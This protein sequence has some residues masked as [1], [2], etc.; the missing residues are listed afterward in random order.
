MAVFISHS[1][2]ETFRWAQNYA[3]SLS[4][5]DVVLLE[6]EMG[7]GKGSRAGSAFRKTF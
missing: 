6:G 4:A 5:G 1:P 7:A 3:K 2:E